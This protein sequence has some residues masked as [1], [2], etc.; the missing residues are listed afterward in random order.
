MRWLLLFGA[1]MMLR[2][3]IK[4]YWVQHDSFKGDTCMALV[5]VL[6]ALSRIVA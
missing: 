6:T 4:Y 5:L 1:F 2:A 3:Q